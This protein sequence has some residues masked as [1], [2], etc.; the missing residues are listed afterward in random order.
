MKR[1]LPLIIIFFAHTCLGQTDTLVNNKLLIKI[2]PASFIDPY[3]GFSWRLGLEYKIGSNWAAC[4]DYGTYFNYSKKDNYISKTNTTGYF[5]RPQIKL[6]LNQRWPN[7]RD[8]LALEY[9]YKN[10]TFNFTDSIRM[11]PFPYP[12][13][14]KTYT[15]FKEINAFTFKYGT[16]QNLK[17]GFIVEWYGG[18]G[19]RFVRGYN[20][21][22]PDQES[23]ILTG[24]NHGPMIAAAT[25]D[26]NITTI[27]FTVGFIVGYRLK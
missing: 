13:Y 20:S 15:I 8:Y 10:T 24:E 9:L 7:E 4:A 1:A 27:N 12:T 2:M 3:G 11:G 21:L 19:V 5:I 22:R 6:Y 25:R 23:H 16:V 17:H 26:V 18:A 14:I